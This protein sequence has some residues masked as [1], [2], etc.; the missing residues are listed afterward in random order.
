MRPNVTNTKVDGIDAYATSDLVTPHPTKKGLYKIVG[1]TDDQIMH[2]T[3]EKVSPP[4]LDSD[5]T[6]LMRDFT[7]EPWT[8]GYVRVRV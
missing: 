1:R 2:S 4:A 5:V 6:R 7:D 3:G 8:V